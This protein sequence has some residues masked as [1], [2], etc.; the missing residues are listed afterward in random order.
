MST[1]PRALW[2]VLLKLKTAHKFTVITCDAHDV[3]PLEQNIVSFL[4]AQPSLLSPGQHPGDQPL[5]RSQRLHARMLLSSTSSTNI[6]WS[7]LC[8]L[9]PL[10]FCLFTATSHLRYLNQREWKS[11]KS[12]HHSSLPIL[13]SSRRNSEKLYVKHASSHS[14]TATGL[15][16]NEANSNAWLF[17][18]GF[19]PLKILKKRNK[20]LR[21]V[22]N[23]VKKSNYDI[24]EVRCCI[25]R[26]P[27]V[28][29]I[30]NDRI[31]FLFF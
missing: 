6:C 5:Q 25:T 15:P 8:L 14:S 2:Q 30:T 1:C 21:K 7:V 13:N 23:L 29:E 4:Y 26:L 27:S 17:Q 16:W 19:N 22:K 11:S 18:V 20:A 9:N 28:L 24:T 10:F 3:V 12:L 31:H